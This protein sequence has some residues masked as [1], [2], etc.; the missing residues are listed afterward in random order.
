MPDPLATAMTNTNPDSCVNVYCERRGKP[1]KISAD[2]LSFLAVW[3]SGVLNGINWQGH[4][5]TEGFVLR[6]YRDNVGIPT[7]G[8]GH[9]IVPAD[10]IQVG[11]S[12]S[13][14][15]AR[16]FKR[17]DLERMERRLNNDIHVP[18]FQFEYDTLVSVVYN[19]GPNAGAD[20]L[21]RMINTGN[22]DE[23]FN[24]IRTYRVG[25]NFNLLPRRYSEARLFASGV[26]DATH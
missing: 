18:L 12:I 22:Y 17:R 26:Y 9:R 8:C 20:Q 3:E 16:E 2:G 1:W 21:I 10:H 19:S 23:M 13:L 24:F 25:S 11:Q 4:Q 5:V 15:R 7:V 14:E 6:A